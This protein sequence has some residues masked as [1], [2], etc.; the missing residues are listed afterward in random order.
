MSVSW[1]ESEL[2]AERWTYVQHLYEQIFARQQQY[3]TLPKSS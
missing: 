1:L 2:T 3:N